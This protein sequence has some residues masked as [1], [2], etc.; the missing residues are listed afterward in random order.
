MGDIT[1]ITVRV[2]GPDGALSRLKGRKAWT[3]RHLIDAGSRGVAPIERPA[4]RWSDYVLHIRR[5]GIIVETIDE[6]HSGTYSGTHGRY[7]LRSPVVIVS[8]ERA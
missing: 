4:P 6:K 1:S 8:E 5:A 2:G 3:L 7:V